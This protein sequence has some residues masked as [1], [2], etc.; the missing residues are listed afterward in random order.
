L[1]FSTRVGTEVKKQAGVVPKLH[2]G[3]IQLLDN[4]CALLQL[5]SVL[6]IDL[7]QSLL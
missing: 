4:S 6:F 1:E 5:V 7:L 3:S 2:S